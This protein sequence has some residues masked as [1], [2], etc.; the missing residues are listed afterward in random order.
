MGILLGDPTDPP[1]HLSLA[2][3]KIRKVVK[4]W[5]SQIGVAAKYLIP[6]REN[7]I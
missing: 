3:Q 6:I 7:M 2:T 1:C 4:E 5:N